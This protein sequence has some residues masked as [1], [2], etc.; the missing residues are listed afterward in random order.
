MT[1]FT[2]TIIPLLCLVATTGCSSC[3]NER[4]PRYATET[5]MAEPAPAEDDE[6]WW[7]AD[8]VTDDEEYVGDAEEE[9]GYYD[10]GDDS[11]ERPDFPR[12]YAR[13]KPVADAIVKL[14]E[15]TASRLKT[16]SPAEADACYKTY[17]DRQEQNV[18]K[19]F[20]INAGWMGVYGEWAGSSNVVSKLFRDTGLKIWGIGEGYNELKFRNY[21][22]W[23]LF[24]PYLSPA[25]RNFLKIIEDESV[26]LY[27]ADAGICL[28]WDEVGERVVRWEKY[29][30][31]YP[32][33]APIDQA[34]ENYIFYLRD[35]LFGE[36]N[37]PT[38]YFEDGKLKIY[39]ES[40]RSYQAL[41][42][43]YPD[44]ITARLLET[45]LK[46]ARNQKFNSDDKYPFF[47]E[48]YK[49]VI[50]MAETAIGM[51]G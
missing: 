8:E 49:R 29:I 20:D 46:E 14:R 34:R 35:Y 33:S 50:D 26:K 43:K 12:L 7:S 2:K 15:E 23:N 37:T 24:G 31:K 27:S 1:H 38:F 6:A 5:A 42:K 40:H 41:L 30:D 47:D 9:E 17:R 21:H 39:D 28:T 4:P 48:F 19:L 51:P 32:D 13:S 22:Y 3:G 44:S 10:A 36:D 16:M 18:E 11:D 25:L 45:F